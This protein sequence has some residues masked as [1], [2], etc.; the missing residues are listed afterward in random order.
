MVGVPSTGSGRPAEPSSGGRNI[1]DADEDVFP[2]RPQWVS[3]TELLYTADGKIKRR[4]A[5]G[6]PA[7]VIEFTANVSFTRPAFTP[8]R[9]NFNLAGPQ[10]ARGIVHP[11][12]SPDGLQVAFA[13]LG[14]LWTMPVGGAPQRLTHDAFVEADPAW[15][16]DGKS[17]AYSSD[18]GGSMNV[19]IRSLRL[20]MIGR[21][22]A[23]PARRCRRHGRP[24]DRES[25]SAIPT[26]RFRSSTWRPA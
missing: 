1:A 18:R 9:K 8:K 24:T 11:V 20:G 13:A 22:P 4:P 14:D 2:F 16:P 19:W 23:A 15:S 7:R 12:I 17:L 10:P 6:G 5:A 3:P 25:R 21:S 26:A